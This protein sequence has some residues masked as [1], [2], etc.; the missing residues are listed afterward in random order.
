MSA[1]GPSKKQDYLTEEQQNIL[2]KK[3]TEIE[4]FQTD[5]TTLAK[6]LITAADGNAFDWS[7]HVTPGTLSV[8][9]EDSSWNRLPYNSE[10]GLLK[11]KYPS[12]IR[13]A[14]GGST[15][16]S[17]WKKMRDLTDSFDE[18]DNDSLSDGDE[19][20]PTVTKF[21]TSERKA[22]GTKTMEEDVI[23]VKCKTCQRPI[24]ASSFRAHSETCGQGDKRPRALTQIE[25]SSSSNNGNNNDKS[26]IKGF[27]SDDDDDDDDDDDPIALKRQND[28]SFKKKKQT[29]KKNNGSGSGGDVIEEALDPTS[30]PAKRPPST[31]E[32]P[33]K[34]KTK[35]E[36]KKAKATPKQKAP[37]DLDK[38]CGVIQ[39]PNNTPC[40]R[41]L[42]CK[43]HSMG[44]KRA[45]AG[46]SQPYDVL[47]SAYQKK[48]I[49]RP[50]STGGSTGANKGA[51]VVAKA[52]TK[53]N[54]KKLQN[55][56]ASPAPAGGAGGA[57]GVGGSTAGGGGSSAAAAAATGGAGGVNA[58]DSTQTNDEQ[59]VN[60][61]EEVENVMH[62]IRTSCPMPLAEKPFYFVKRRRQCYR[63]RDIL[64]DTIT[65][66]FVSMAHSDSNSSLSS[67]YNNNNNNNNTNTSPSVHN[68][69]ST[70]SPLHPQ[71]QL[72]LPQHAFQPAHTMM[73]SPANTAAMNRI[74]QPATGLAGPSLGMIGF[75]GSMDAGTMFAS[76]NGN[77]RDTL[78]K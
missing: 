11:R 37:L 27:F 5:I 26:N 13:E 67:L 7:K 72:H 39:G 63:L 71:Q 47:L 45:V 54:A 19:L 56:T 66:K 8:F 41:S 74:S 10:S 42:T 20:S 2:S 31:N 52:T 49:G 48:A 17:A 32:K 75:S 30:V 53:L 38:Q 62:A 43:S 24:L 40:T 15:S 57:G 46:R 60:S 21:E 59:F 76:A 61:D 4:R 6:P 35:K 14:T 68:N 34:K 28:P 50:Q 36:Q 55:R 65:P 69:G 77:M 58:Q 70:P 1:N 73:N 22:F 33:E 64:F 3:G 12:D 51:T 29:D 23:V 44:A 25:S 9:Q 78:Q 16:S 18:A